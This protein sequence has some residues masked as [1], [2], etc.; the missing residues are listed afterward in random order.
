MP[1]SVD[2]DKIVEKVHKRIP[3]AR[4]E[5]TDE[6]LPRWHVANRAA[7]LEYDTDANHLLVSGTKSGGSTVTRKHKL[8]DPASEIAVVIVELLMEPVKPVEQGAE[9]PV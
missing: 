8:D 3:Y 2:F 6:R 9:R 1:H 5:M 7:W 4:V